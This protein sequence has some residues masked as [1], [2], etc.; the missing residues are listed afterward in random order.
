MVRTLLCSLLV[1]LVGRSVAQYPF[2]RT[3]EIKAGQ[4]RPSISSMAQDGMG[5][6]WV[7]S[8]LGLMRTDGERTDLVYTC[9]PAEISAML[10]TDDGVIT[11][12]ST[13]QV[14]RC[15]GYD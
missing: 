5:L 10:G 8:D 3:F 7:A 4:E 15:H 2:T 6:L 11:V 13:G 1:M 14:V 9:A 12:L